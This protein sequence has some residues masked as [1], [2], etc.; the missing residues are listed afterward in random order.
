MLWRRRRHD[1]IDFEPN[2]RA[3]VDLLEPRAKDIAQQEVDRSQALDQKTAGLIAAALVL[4]VAGVAFASRIADLQ[5]GSGART[6]W[7]VIIGASLILLLVS[8]GFATAAIRPQAFRTVI[9]IDE[10]DR[11]ATPRFLDRAPTQV[12]G[13]I[14]RAHVAAVRAA[15]SI[16]KRKGDRLAL[17]FG[18]FAA[19]IIATVVLGVA[20]AIRLAEPPHHHVS[21]GPPHTIQ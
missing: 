2:I 12:R 9:H 21:R 5:A 11:W 3:N 18:F 19:A 1:S 13:E 8:L 17:A 15:R 16:N 6:L 20:V 10:L 7:V 4:V 14:M